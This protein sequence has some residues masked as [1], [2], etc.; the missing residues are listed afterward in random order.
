ML[1]SIEFK[2]ES[3]SFKKGRTISTI[4]VIILLLFIV[5]AVYMA[6]K[7]PKEE[8]EAVAEPVKEA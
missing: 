1:L 6:S 2:I 7:E 5:L 8:P 4:S 3:N